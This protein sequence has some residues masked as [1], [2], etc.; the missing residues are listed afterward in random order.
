MSSLI[1]NPFAA[2]DVNALI[3]KRM[4]EHAPELDN[5]LRE[6]GDISD[7]VTARQCEEHAQYEKKMMAIHSAWSQMQSEM[8]AL[9]HLFE[10]A[11]Q[12]VPA[13]QPDGA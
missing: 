11:P 2:D 4:A 3:A 5:I 6:L 7:D 10:M 13:V 9:Q 8:A 12:G 1:V